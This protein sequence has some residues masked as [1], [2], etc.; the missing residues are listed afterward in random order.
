MIRHQLSPLFPGSRDSHHRTAGV[1]DFGTRGQVV[2]YRVAAF[3]VSR[4]EESRVIVPATVES[5]MVRSHQL[6]EPH[7]A[8]N[9]R[10]CPYFQTGAPELFLSRSGCHQT[11]SAQRFNED[12]HHH[13][14][15]A[16]A[17]R[18]WCNRWPIAGLL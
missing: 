17:P 16:Y 9:R 18:N 11:R 5:L 8:L 3:G 15:H 13:R 12:R 10:H 2:Q 1:H 7:E 4:R 6:S 14:R